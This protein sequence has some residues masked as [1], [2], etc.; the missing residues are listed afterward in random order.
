M[1]RRARQWTAHDLRRSQ[2]A[3][4]AHGH[5]PPTRLR[6]CRRELTRKVEQLEADN[7]GLNSQLTASQAEVGFAQQRLQEGFFEDPGWMT[8]GSTSKVTVAF[9]LGLV[10]GWVTLVRTLR[11]P[12]LTS[13]YT[14]CAVNDESVWDEEAN[15]EAPEEP[16]PLCGCGSLIC[17]GAVFPVMSPGVT[18]GGALIP[19]VLASNH[20]SCAFQIVFSSR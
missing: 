17:S 15:E 11:L 12:N 16:S 3:S 7:Q 19:S 2:R 18:S 10:F 4:S 20:E 13:Q 5:R 1:R 8:L 14:P 9:Q 6:E